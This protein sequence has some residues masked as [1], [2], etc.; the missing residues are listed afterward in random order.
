MAMVFTQGD[1]YRALRACC[2]R[3]VAVMSRK[4]R[5][6][7]AKIAAPAVPLIS[8]L[9]CS[10]PIESDSFESERAAMVA[11]I[12]SYRGEATKVLGPQGFDPRVLE[13]M[14]TVPRHAFVPGSEQRHAYDDRPLPIGFGQTI[15]QPLIVALMTDLLRPQPDHVILE[16][17]TGSGYQAAVLAHLVRQ[18]HTIEIVM[19]LA[20][21]AK[22]K[23]AE[24]GYDNVEVRAGDGYAGWKEAGPFDG[25]LVTAG[26]DH[27]PPQ[28]V[29]QLKPGARMVI[30]VGSRH[31]VQYLTLVEA[32]DD[33]TVQT[34]RLL[35]VR[36]VPLTGR[37]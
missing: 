17:G 18:V 27:I 19:P 34:R 7:L 31:D 25:I 11:V 29:E 5:P 3:F 13:V 6:R 26:A 10:A 36:F 30:P 24:L 14:R 12:E 32:A 33:G 35:A 21:Q 2:A 20:E 15:S 28:L 23:L 8:L 16:V 1:V 9:T 22:A 4:S 37:R